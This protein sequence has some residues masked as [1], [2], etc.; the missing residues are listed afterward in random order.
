MKERI[1]T[2]NIIQRYSDGS[3]DDQNV[4]TRA[5]SEADARQKIRS[6]YHNIVDM[7][8]LKVE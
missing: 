8:L 7:T 3:L 5:I 4:W 6:E 2:F 1:Y